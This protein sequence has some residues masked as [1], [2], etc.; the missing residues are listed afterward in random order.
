MARVGAGS[1]LQGLNK[2]KQISLRVGECGDPQVRALPAGRLDDPNS[3]PFQPSEL[4]IHIVG[5]QADE[6]PRRVTVGA[7]DLAVGDDEQ[8][9]SARLAEHREPVV[10]EQKRQSE[11]ISVERQ[12]F[13]KD[14]PELRE[15]LLRGENVLLAPRSGARPSCR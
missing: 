8:R 14:T 2:R 7:A 11:D 5:T 6:I 12:R 3:R 9:A 15:D 1:G 13:T 4:G 10:V